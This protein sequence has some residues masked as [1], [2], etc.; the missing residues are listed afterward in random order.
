MPSQQLSLKSVC[1]RSN[2][3]VARDISGTTL[4]VPLSAGIV[5][6]DGELFALSDSGRAIWQRLDG[7]QDLAA[8][9]LSLSRLF[10]ASIYEI[11][12]AVLAFAEELRFRK[13]LVIA[14]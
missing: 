8:V 9:A 2:C 3:V 13:L 6:V 12:N 5:E 7:E 11:E 14:H 10:N 4:I 1:A